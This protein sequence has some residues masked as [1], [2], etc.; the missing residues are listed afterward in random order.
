V[1]VSRVVTARAGLPLHTRIDTSAGKAH[2]WYYSYVKPISLSDKCRY[3]VDLAKCNC[4]HF[5]DV[6]LIGIFVLC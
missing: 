3:S 4:T 1:S 2:R 6:K 5:K